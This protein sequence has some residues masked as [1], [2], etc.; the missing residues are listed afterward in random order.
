M[1]NNLKNNNPTGHSYPPAPRATRL[2]GR[3]ITS[4]TILPAPIA[5]Y[6]LLISIAA[7]LSQSQSVAWRLAGPLLVDIAKAGASYI[8]YDS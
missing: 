6:E 8:I 1:C 4:R 5:R 2:S 7:I 3:L